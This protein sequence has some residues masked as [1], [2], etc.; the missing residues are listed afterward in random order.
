VIV[1]DTNVL[2]ALMRPVPDRAVALWIDSVPR[3]TIW[4]TSITMF[5][6]RVGLDVMPAGRRRRGLEE[7]FLHLVDEEL[8]RRILEFD[9]QAAV[10]SAALASRRQQRGR[11]IDLRDTLIAGIAVARAATLATRNGRHFADLDVPVVN[12][13]L[14]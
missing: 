11:P 9:A 6:V 1:L 2:S 13:W 10:A 8:E 12:P 3:E 14:E 4:I 5:E 7:A